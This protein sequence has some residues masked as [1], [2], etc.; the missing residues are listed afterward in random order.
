MLN[1]HPAIA[2]CRETDFYHYVYKRRHRFGDLNDLRN[3]RRLV[4]EYLG[5]Q[6]IQRMRLDLQALE[7]RL[8]Q[9]GT[10]YPAFFAALLRF[11]AET[12]GKQRCGEKTPEH[13][14]FTETLCEWYPD[15]AIIHVV[16]D[17]RDV[18]ASLRHLPWAPNNAIGNARLWFTRNLAARRSRHRPQYLL[19]RY[20]ELVTQPEGELR[21]ICAFLGEDYSPAML[22]PNWDPTADRP[23]FQRAEQ[24]VTTARIGTWRTELSEADV[25]L[26]EWVLGA[27]M[28]TFGYEPVGRT[29]SIIC[30]LRG[31]VFGAANAVRRRVGEFPGVWYWVTRSTKLAKE[32]TA[33]ER[34]R[35]RHL[36][37][38]ARTWGT[39]PGR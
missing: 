29:P 27:H 3:R 22:V 5:I 20:E 11:Y 1:R 24:S 21:R 37:A 18:V 14:L 30:L 10:S 39:G 32:E 28:K 2:V 9:D 26:V 23:W 33:K 36:A 38:A 12:H 4:R 16:R 17:P 19:V 6:R 13:A 34:F 35:S 7:T 8:L 15:A 31:L 25:A